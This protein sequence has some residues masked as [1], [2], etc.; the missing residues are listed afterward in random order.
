MLRIVAA[1]GD[2][3]PN[4]PFIGSANATTRLIYTYGHRNIQGLAAR[5][6]TEQMWSVEHGPTVDDE[7]NLL[8]AGG[9]AGWNPVPGYNESVP[10]TDFS[11]PDA[12]APAWSTGSSTLALSGGEWFDDPSW[13]AWNGGLAVAALKNQ[14]LRLLF[15]SPEGVYLGQKTILDGEFGR[16]RAVQQAADGSIYVTTS[17]GDDQIVRLTAT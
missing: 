4:N 7:V 14:T 11:L 9:N 3:A 10:M 13:G 15:F 17:R 16:L 6:G 8:P 5:P 2:P 1:T 12:F